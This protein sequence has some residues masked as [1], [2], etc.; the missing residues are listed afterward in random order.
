MKR[1]KGFV[2]AVMLVLA[3]AGS[4]YGQDCHDRDGDGDVDLDD[5]VVVKDGYGKTTEP[6]RGGDLN[7][8]GV[9]DL[10]DLAMMKDWFI[11]GGCGDP[12]GPAPMGRME[13]FIDSSGEAFLSNPTDSGIPFGG[14][15]IKS[16]SGQLDIAQWDYLL[17][18]IIEAM[19]TFGND[20]TNF[21][22][23][24]YLGVAAADFS[25]EGV[26]VILRRSATWSSSTRCIR[27]PTGFVPGS[28]S[29]NGPCPEMRTW[30][31]TSIWTTSPP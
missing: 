3:A 13:L 10:F 12:P 20:I 5:F 27:P 11:G 15:E 2:L 17:S 8:D 9:C 24:F 25:F 7:G 16:A 21:G 18:D 29:P 28:S 19:Q 22:N 30:T 23:T 4:V 26:E 31:A 1:T 6:Y 14:Y